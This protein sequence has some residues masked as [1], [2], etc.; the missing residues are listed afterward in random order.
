[1]RKW[2][3]ILLLVALSCVREAEEP[4]RKSVPF[5]EGE[6]VEITFTINDFTPSVSPQTKAATIGETANMETLYVGVFGRSGYLKE[7]V[8]AT[9]VKMEQKK[10]YPYKE[11]G[12]ETLYADVDQYTYTVTLS[13]AES[14]R[15]VHLIGNG[16][17]VL[18]FGYDNKILPNLLCNEG[19]ACFW[20]VIELEDGILAAQD[21]E[22][23]YLNPQGEIRTGSEPYGADAGT[24]RAFSNDGEGIPMVRNWAKL[25]LR[26]D[27]DSNFTPYSFAVVNIPTKGTYCPYS[28]QTNIIE[29]FNTGFIYHYENFSFKELDYDEETL[30]GLYYPGN[31]PTNVP[32]SDVVPDIADFITPN[33]VVA[34]AQ[35][36]HAGTPQDPY[37]GVYMYERPAPSDEMPP[38]YVIVY[39]HYKN[40]QDESQAAFEDDYFYKVDLM[41]GG[42]YYPIFRNFK[43]EIVI[44]SI[45]APGFST[46]LAAAQAAGSAD[47]SADIN[48]A[49]L[50]DIS[51]GTRRMV[52]RPW[53][54]KTF[55]S[56]KTDFQ[57][58]SVIYY[59]NVNGAN[60]QPDKTDGIVTIER[61]APEDGL[62]ENVITEYKIDARAD[63]ATGYRTITISTAAPAAFSRTQKLRVKGTTDGVTLYRDIEITVQKLQDMK[64]Q[65]RYSQI[66]EWQKS[67]QILDVYI[68]NGLARS[69]F[70]LDFVIETEDLTLT[71]DNTVSDNNLPVLWGT[72]ITGVD[73][74]A[75]Q[76][77]KSIS[78]DDYRSLELTTD[79]NKATWRKFSCYFISNC[80]QSATTIWVDNEYFN[81]NHIS[82]GSKKS[83]GH[84]K[85][86]S[87]IPAE[88]DASVTVG[89]MIP[90]EDSGEYADILFKLKNLVPADMSAWTVVDAE[91][92]EYSFT[93]T[94]AEYELE[95]LTTTA[96]G[97]ISVTIS[98]PDEPSFGEQTITPYRFSPLGFIP[99]KIPTSATDV[100]GGNNSN[101]VYGRCFRWGTQDKFRHFLYGYFDD[102]ASPNPEYTLKDF[103]G[104]PVDRTNM[105]GKVKLV[106]S[107]N[108]VKYP[109][110]TTEHIRPATQARSTL[111]HEFEFVANSEYT[112]PI[113]FII[114]AVG[115]VELKVQGLRLNGTVQDTWSNGQSFL[116]PG[117][118]VSKTHTYTHSNIKVTFS[119]VSSVDSY[120]VHLDP[121]Q[122]YTIT[123]EVKDASFDGF[124]YIQLDFKPEMDWLGVVRDMDPLSTSPAAT[125]YYGNQQS[126]YWIPEPGQ[127]T[128]AVTLHPHQDYPIIVNGVFAKMYKGLTYYDEN[129]DA[130]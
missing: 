62:P 130:Q 77:K 23:N 83:F 119:D 118:A 114:S 39:G 28:G 12:G 81:A 84:F 44:K 25:E 75:F 2:L 10:H 121:G 38:S 127:K 22:G 70:P 74:Q 124:Y 120:G 116:N 19:Q 61:L 108:D 45:T 21:D 106:W 24:I 94:Q 13:L 107:K 1:M 54:E 32:F 6:P 27:P 51:D 31:L 9:P 46:P 86:T 42:R 122:D 100:W 89:V 88:T 47:V 125:M 55:T 41:E 96:D 57:D 115:Y 78:W 59:R 67:S 129:G 58:L 64:L 35:A 29:R 40:T 97:D 111:Y 110:P 92:G 11:E 37:E 91:E 87:P 30:E 7:Y 17:S 36:A 48:T 93:P 98:C 4:V 105:P 126:W 43:Y 95:F 66:P 52:I 63:A 72:S 109:W 112:Q 71:P 20:Q 15:Y 101:V 99:K 117:G 60:P 90:E 3:F 34:N 26:A 113:E 79:E 8:Q 18:E 102:P 33:G 53:L 5:P 104:N 16:P 123:F 73:K 82:F 50:L 76:F 68:P 14:K 103:D 65:C 69:M 128:F 80:D 49:H 56:A 85:Y